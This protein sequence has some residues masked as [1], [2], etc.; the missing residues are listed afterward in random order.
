MV[1]SKLD[2]GSRQIGSSSCLFRFYALTLKWCDFTHVFFKFQAQLLA[3]TYTGENKLN[4][5]L[6]WTKIKEVVESLYC[7]KAS[8]NLIADYYKTVNE[9]KTTVW[10]ELCFTFSN[11]NV[12]LQVVFPCVGKK[13]I[14]HFPQF[15]NWCWLTDFV[16]SFS[17]V[18]CE[19]ARLP[20][21]VQDTRSINMGQIKSA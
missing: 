20:L 18:C 13:L 12:Q 3:P 17:G 14:T 6:V 1:F 19:R 4:E 15:Q 9:D 8:W 16:E 5:H 11:T 21:P 10:A 7:N 2:T